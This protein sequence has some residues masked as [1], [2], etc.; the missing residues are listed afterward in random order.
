MNRSDNKMAAPEASVHLVRNR[1][2]LP[3]LPLPNERKSLRKCFKK[4]DVAY[5]L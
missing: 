2:F 1:L 4:D 3:F 5:K